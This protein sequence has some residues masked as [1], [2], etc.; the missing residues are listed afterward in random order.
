MSKI[1]YDTSSPYYGTPQTNWYLGPIA[2]RVI[3]P[4]T[5]DRYVMLDSKYE[6]RPDTLST[7][8]YGSPRYW[9]VFMIRNMNDIRDPIWDQKAGMAIYVPTIERLQQLLG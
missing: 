8:L 3:P 6:Y 1:T 7:D 5:S 2:L 4:H 9:W